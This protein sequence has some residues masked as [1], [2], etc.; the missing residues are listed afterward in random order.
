M[1]VG[2]K[3]KDIFLETTLKEC[4]GCQLNYGNQE[5]HFCLTDKK[6]RARALFNILLER[7]DINDELKRE[8]L[9]ELV[10]DEEW[11]ESVIEINC[12][13]QTSF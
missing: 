5:G 13:N 11:V 12:S 6:E 8:N 3:M 1:T 4:E 10:K 2:E 9:E 7:I